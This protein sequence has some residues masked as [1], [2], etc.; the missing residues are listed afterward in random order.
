ML[1]IAKKGE[2][3]QVDGQL[4]DLL[5]TMET[6]R[7]LD[8]RNLTEPSQRKQVE[9]LL[10]LLGSTIQVCSERKDQIA[11]LINAFAIAINTPGEP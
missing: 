3:D 9:Q 4:Q 5:L 1:D 10:E 2:W 7:S 11:P 8:F 6:L